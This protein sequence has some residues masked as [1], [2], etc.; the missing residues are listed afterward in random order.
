M[1]ERV[2]LARC[3]YVLFFR[4]YLRVTSTHYSARVL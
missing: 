1:K 4:R 3:S 2:I